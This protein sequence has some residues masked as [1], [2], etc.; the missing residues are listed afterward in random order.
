[1]RQPPS[2]HT[3]SVPD[4]D[5]DCDTD[6]IGCLKNMFVDRVQ[7]GRIEQGQC[8]ARRP[9]FLRLHGGAHGTL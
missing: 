4:C 8:P 9:V 6:P 1:M 5:C 3:A 7:F 2:V